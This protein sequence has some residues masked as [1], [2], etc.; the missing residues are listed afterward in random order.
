M[1]PP[2]KDLAAPPTLDSLL[3]LILTSRVYDVARETAANVSGISGL[4][5][6]IA[7]VVIMRMVVMRVEGDIGHGLTCPSCCRRRRR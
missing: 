5:G 7:G 6:A 1:I 3:R 4:L 2:V